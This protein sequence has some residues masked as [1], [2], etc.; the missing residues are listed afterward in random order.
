MDCL[1][2]HEQTGTYQKYPSKAG[3]P[4]EEPTEFGNE[5]FYP[6]NWNKV[7]QTVG[8]PSRH[9]C[10][11]CHFYG[12]GGDG[13]KHGDLD[14]S[15]LNPSKELDVHMATEGAN[16]TCVRCHTT[17]AHKISGRCYKKPA[18][19]EY[20]SLIQDDLI[21]RISCVSCHTETPHEPGS[22]ENDHTDIVACQSCHI[23]HYARV[24][25]TKM[26]WDW[27]TAGQLRNGKPYTITGE[28]GK[29]SYDTRK[30]SFVWEKNVEPEYFWFNGS[31]EYVLF[32][33][34]ID[35]SQPVSLNSVQGERGEK[36]ARI[37]PFKVHKAKQPYDTGQNTMAALHLFSPKEPTAYWGSFDWDKAIESGMEYVGLT[38]SGEFDFVETVYHFPITHMVAPKENSLACSECHARD[39]RMADLAGFYMPG[40]DFHPV[41]DTIGWVVVFGSLA[42]VIIHGLIRV[43]TRKRRA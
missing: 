41:L 20:K 5:T 36:R 21:D 17:D 1:V 6:P 13:V 23:P 37:Y 7:S 8:R 29:H 2:C 24:L 42:A 34:T 18:F 25:P 19:E 11:S 12:G 10:G 22:K 3:H 32:T 30:G 15:L 14:S 31:L 38:Y 35:P 43:A 39:G 4:V 26:V 33:D 27:S 40:R 9:N 28:Y 16:F